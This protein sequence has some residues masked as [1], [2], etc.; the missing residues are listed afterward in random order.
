VKLGTVKAVRNRYYVTIGK[1][2]REIPVGEIISAA[3]VKKAVGEEVPV[4]VS[5]RV[6]VAIGLPL[7]EKLRRWILCYLPPP[8]FL[9]EIGP[10]LRREVI[11]R[12]VDM[13][14]I[15]KKVG[16]LLT[17]ELSL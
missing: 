10:D 1:T 4:I 11:A 3:D 16:E 12:Y 17:R 9:K 6:V 13:N 2:Q 14:V 5:G 8:D 7:R 15:P